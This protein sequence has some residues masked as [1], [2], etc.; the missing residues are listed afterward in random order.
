MAMS[1]DIKMSLARSEVLPDV[2]DWLEERH[3]F[4]KRDWDYTKP[5]HF[6]DDWDF[7]FK[8]E[9]SED[10]TVFALRWA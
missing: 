3:L 4:F 6:K 10:A 1:Y 5:D 7:T 2:F 8:F 9:R